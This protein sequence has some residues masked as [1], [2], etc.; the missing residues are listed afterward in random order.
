MANDGE[1]T[2][3]DALEQGYFEDILSYFGNPVGES[4]LTYRSELIYEYSPRA[5]GGEK[6]YL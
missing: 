2:R 6:G 4:T 5:W 1:E 3:R